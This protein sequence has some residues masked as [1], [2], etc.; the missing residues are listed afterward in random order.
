MTFAKSSQN[1]IFVELNEINFD[2]V[3]DYVALG[4]LPTFGRLIADHGIIETTS[5][6][7][8]DLLEPWI[9][10]VTAH[11]GK[12][13]KEHGVFR[14]GDIVNHDIPQIWEFLEANGLAVGAISPMNAKNRTKRAAFFLPDPWTQTP[15]TGGQILKGLSL[16]VSQAVNDNAKSEISLRSLCWL[17]VGFA[18]FARPANYG[19]YIGLLA[20][21]LRKQGW[22][23]AQIL[24]QLLADLLIRETHAKKP[25]FVSLF[26]NAGAHIQHHYLFNSAVYEGKN[27]NPAWLIGP[28]TDPVFDIY[29]QYDRIINQIQTRFP[30]SRLMLAT[31]LH[32][33]PYPNEKYYWRLRDHASFLRKMEVPFVSVEPRMSRDF[34]V[35]C[36]DPRTAELAAHRLTEIV[37]RDGTPLFEVDLR[38]TDLFVMLIYPLDIQSNLGFTVGR[39]HHEDLRQHVAF[40]AFKNG[41]HN[42]KGYFI[43]TSQNGDE[44]GPIALKTIPMRIS[45]AFG[46]QWP[47]HESAADGAM[48][49]TQHCELS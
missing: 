29:D 27:A 17:I 9:Q 25:D 12:S 42:G 8:Y 18:R 35:T 28:S 2:F 16:A 14:L 1:V 4:K 3:K 36:G 24:E 47:H 26:L 44:A 49:Q 41:E 31:G 13:F 19:R 20:K 39:E 23:K 34:L 33:D 11:T 6:D 22:A 21:G 37:T 10:W 43:D 5:E 45:E 46:L 40:V 38:G 30:K 7:D 48:V 32:Q 15:A